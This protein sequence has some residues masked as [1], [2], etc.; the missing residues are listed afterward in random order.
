ML[1]E[2]GPTLR[3][4]LRFFGAYGVLALLYALFIRS[5]DTM[6]PP[7]LDPFSRWVSHQVEWVEET[8]LG[9]E[10]EVIEDYH[11]EFA[12]QPEQTYD[13]FLVDGK[14]TVALEEGC[15]GLAMMYL[16]ASFVFAF[17]GSVRTMALYI[18]AGLLF[19]HAANL[20]RLAWL[21]ELNMAGEGTWFHFFHKYGFTGVIYGAVFLLWVLWVAR[22]SGLQQKKA[23]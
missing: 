1:K 20:F 17:G 16:F 8:F 9:R 3:F 5:Y 14:Y 22:F 18:P 21:I 15:N 19:L 2:F 23:A 10:V 11:L 12:A 13:G 7:R 4:L 6:E